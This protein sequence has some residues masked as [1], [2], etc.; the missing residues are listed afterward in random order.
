MLCRRPT[1]S[2]LRGPTSKLVHR[3][4]GL[5]LWQLHA[6]HRGAP[7]L[8]LVHPFLEFEQDIPDC[9]LCY[10]R[11]TDWHDSPLTETR[12]ALVLTKQFMS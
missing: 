12:R 7:G 9:R 2:S 8:P 4:G 10:R 1:V 6:P 3:F 5:A 11:A